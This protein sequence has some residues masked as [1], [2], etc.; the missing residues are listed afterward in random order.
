MAAK[1]PERSIVFHPVDEGAPACRRFGKGAPQAIDG[2][3]QLA[4]SRVGAAQI[5]AGH[6]IAGLDG[7]SAVRPFLRALGVAH[8]GLN[9]GTEGKRTGIVRLGGELELQPVEASPGRGHGVVVAIQGAV[10]VDR[11]AEP[12]K[13]LEFSSAAR[14]NSRAA[15]A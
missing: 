15:L 8:F 1:R 2:V 6:H 3:I 14:S 9:D 12:R 11:K 13:S 4:K 7:D 5:V 10:F